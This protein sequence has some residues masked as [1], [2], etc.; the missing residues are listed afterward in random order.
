MEHSS[1]EYLVFHQLINKLATFYGTRG[2][3]CRI[4]KSPPLVTILSQSNPFNTIP[5]CFF[6]IGLNISFPSTP[7][8]FKRIL[9]LL[10][11]SEFQR[12]L[13]EVLVTG[14]V[15]LSKITTISVRLIPF[16]DLKVGL[17]EQ[18]ASTKNIRPQGK[19]MCCSKRFDS[20]DA[21]PLNISWE[22]FRFPLS[23]RDSLIQQS[24]WCLEKTVSAVH[25]K[26]R[27]WFTQ[28]LY[29]SSVM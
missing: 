10:V 9:R 12:T 3:N 20:P 21:E 8:S 2:L 17:S 29:L 18:G 4:H 6:N 19:R 28:S 14:L 16:P 7:E 15:G 5:S 1:C 27:N 11:K 24:F 13:K 23:S 25:V 26:A 22:A